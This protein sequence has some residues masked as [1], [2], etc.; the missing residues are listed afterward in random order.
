MSTA[1]E[2]RKARKQKRASL[3]PMIRGRWVGHGYIGHGGY[4][5]T[6]YENSG[7]LPDPRRPAAGR[8]KSK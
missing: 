5:N 8:G 7:T 2:I 3:A 4:D 1:R 6:D